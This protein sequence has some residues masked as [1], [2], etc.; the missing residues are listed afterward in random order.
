LDEFLKVQGN[1]YPNTGR[2]LESST[3]PRPGWYMEEISTL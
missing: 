3:P 1:P 2:H